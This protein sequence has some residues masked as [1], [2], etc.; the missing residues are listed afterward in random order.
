MKTTHYILF[1]IAMSS[2]GVACAVK[3]QTVTLEYK[4][5][6]INKAYVPDT[7]IKQMLLPYADSVHKAMGIVIGTSTAYLEKQQPESVLGNFMADC[8]R[9]MASRKFNTGVDAAF[10]NYYGIRSDIPQGNISLGNIYDLMPFDNLIVLQSLKGS[11]LRELL[12]LIASKGGWPMSGIRMQIQDKHAVN[13][14]VNGNP[15]DDNA[16]YLV[17]NS[18]YVANGGDD[19]KMLK[20]IPQQSKGYLYRDALIDYIQEL[21]RAGKPVSA[22]IE[23]RVTYVK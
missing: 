17:A 21:T 4:D 7:G 20:E 18:D 3:R 14:V 1:G 10:V 13:I 22:T 2:I 19:C 8:M 12:N 9:T 5:Y 16:T 15:L 23:N 6:E 11:V